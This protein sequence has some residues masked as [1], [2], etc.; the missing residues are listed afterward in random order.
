MKGLGPWPYVMFIRHKAAQRSRDCHRQERLCAPS[1]VG[2]Y[3]NLSCTCGM[4]D[5]VVVRSRTRGDKERVSLGSMY[6]M[7]DSSGFS[8]LI[9]NTS[10]SLPAYTGP[11]S[12][13]AEAR[14]RH[15]TAHDD[16]PVPGFAQICSKLISRLPYA[17]KLQLY[18][19]DTI[20]FVG[21]CDPF[22]DV[23]MLAPLPR[24]VSKQAEV[25]L[26]SA[27]HDSSEQL[28]RLR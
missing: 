9:S 3:P 10:I 16:S 21:H 22:T 2:Q 20:V 15:A 27:A 13:H 11:C 6:V 25:S 28:V 26:L 7:V 19:S 8:R 12:E 4:S 23:D 24:L 1:N 17:C 14:P 5:V 18:C